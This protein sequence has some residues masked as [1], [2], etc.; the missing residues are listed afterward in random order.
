MVQE[1]VSDLMLC[2]ETRQTKSNNEAE[3]YATTYKTTRLTIHKITIDMFTAA[4]TSNLET[5]SRTHDVYRIH[6][7]LVQAADYLNSHFVNSCI[8][9]LT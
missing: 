9:W 7:L 4:R 6:S 3:T 5:R 1:N 8:H 2:V